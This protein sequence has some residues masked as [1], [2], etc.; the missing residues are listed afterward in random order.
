MGSMKKMKEI[1]P[2]KVIGGLTVGVA[3]AA[4]FAFLFGKLVQFLWNATI[5]DI[6]ELKEI[7]YWQGVGLLLLARTLVGGMGHGGNHHKHHKKFKDHWNCNGRDIL[8]E[9]A[10]EE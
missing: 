10:K 4:L 8:E 5:S 9:Q 1:N 7:T 3:I 2:V 6:F